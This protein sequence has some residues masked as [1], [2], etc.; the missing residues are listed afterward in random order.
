MGRYPF[1]GLGYQ[2]FQGW[3]VAGEIIGSNHISFNMLILLKDTLYITPLG[4]TQFSWIWTELVSFYIRE[5]LKELV[6]YSVGYY[7]G[8]IYLGVW[9]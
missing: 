3:V 9:D 8:K 7:F 4:L 1:E 6:R 2:F 5:V